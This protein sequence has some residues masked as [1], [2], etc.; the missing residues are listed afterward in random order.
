MYLLRLLFY[1]LITQIHFSHTSSSATLTGTRYCMIHNILSF[2]LLSYINITFLV[3]VSPLQALA[4]LRYGHRFDERKVMTLKWREGTTFV[5]KAANERRGCVSP[6]ERDPSLPSAIWLL[7]GR[8]IKF[9]FLVP[10]S[11][12]SR[13]YFGRR[14][15]DS[16]TA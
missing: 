12:C 15:S 13:N 14:M 6:E 2:F 11:P 9:R 16:S 4:R 3:S 8:M 7:R 5:S 1:R 10:F